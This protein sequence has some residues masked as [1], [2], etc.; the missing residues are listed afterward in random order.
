MSQSKRQSVIET[1]SNTAV[2]FVGS[3]LITFGCFHLSSNL[4]TATLYATLG[5]TVWSL[6][7][8]YYLRRLFNKLH[9][10]PAVEVEPVVGVKPQPVRRH[11]RH[12]F[13]K[14]G[15]ADSHHAIEDSN[16]E[17][18]LTYCRLCKC[19]EGELP[20]E[21]PGVEVPVEDRFKLYRGELDYRWG[22]WRVKPTACDCGANTQCTACPNALE[23][24][25][26]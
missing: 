25:T 21:C 1:C 3:Y 7:R 23:N 12:D 11:G 13:I 18:A 10:K 8:G 26:T 14:T 19:A 5:C 20:T 6:L 17:V 9:A 16:G 4:P 22:A 2:G 15:D 24:A